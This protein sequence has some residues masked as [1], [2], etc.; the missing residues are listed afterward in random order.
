[1]MTLGLQCGHW[2]NG[3]DDFILS[4]TFKKKKE[5]KSDFVVVFDLFHFIIRI[6][7]CRIKYLKEIAYKI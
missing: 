1:M 4:N 3:E 7:K 5:M 2:P 6:N